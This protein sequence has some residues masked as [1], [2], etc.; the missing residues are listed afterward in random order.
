VSHRKSPRQEAPAGS[1][2]RSLHRRTL[3][4]E[5]ILWALNR[6]P[7]WTANEGTI[8]NLVEQLGAYLS[9]RYTFEIVLVDDG[10]PDDSALTCK[11]LAERYPFVKAVCL[12]RTFGEHNA[13]MAGLNHASGDAVVIMDD[14]LA[15]SASRSSLPGWGSLDL[16]M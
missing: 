1:A 14:D 12:A 8:P 6:Q 5:V 11:Q 16:Q 4:R 3:L 2:Q 15:E 10:S 13:V 7:L 9:H